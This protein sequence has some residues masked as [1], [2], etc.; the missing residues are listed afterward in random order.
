MVDFLE[1]KHLLALAA[2]QPLEEELA[3]RDDGLVQEGL[4]L[5]LD[6][7]AITLAEAHEIVI[8]R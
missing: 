2:E 6:E 7:G 3:V 5:H 8:R 1:R 4:R